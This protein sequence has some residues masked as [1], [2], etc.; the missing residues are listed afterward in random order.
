[1]V[2]ERLETHNVLKATGSKRLIELEFVVSDLHEYLQYSICAERKNERKLETYQQQN[3]L[4][5][6][7]FHTLHLDRT[8][9]SHSI[10]CAICLDWPS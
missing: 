6:V 9:H 7:N 1:M 8:H 5:H 4:N 10:C 3:S 2:M